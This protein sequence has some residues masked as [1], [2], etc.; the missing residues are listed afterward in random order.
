MCALEIWTQVFVLWSHLPSSFYFILQ[1]ENTQEQSIYLSHLV[2]LKVSFQSFWE[3]KSLSITG[4]APENPGLY[5]QGRELLISLLLLQPHLEVKLGPCLAHP[6]LWT[7]NTVPHV[8]HTAYFL[9]MWFFSLRVEC[10]KKKDWLMEIFVY[11]PDSR[12]IFRILS[13]CHRV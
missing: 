9:S 6:L 7:I 1:M 4:G 5:S 3:L 8:L 11:I 10:R 13:I 2:L 12:S